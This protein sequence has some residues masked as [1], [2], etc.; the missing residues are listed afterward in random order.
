MKEMKTYKIYGITAAAVCLVAAFSTVSCSKDV[1]IGDPVPVNA[2]YLL[3][4]TGASDEDNARIMEIYEKWSSYVLYDV[5]SADVYWTQVAGTASGGT[6]VYQ[7]EDADPQYVG[8]MLYYLN[9]VW[10]QYFP[11]EFLQ[12][13]GIP[14]R[15]YLVE[16]YYKY[17]DWGSSGVSANTYLDYRIDDNYSYIIV[18]GMSKVASMDADTKRDKKFFLLN[19][20]FDKWTTKGVVD[21]PEEFYTISDYTTEP[22]MTGEGEDQYG[23]PVIAFTDEE[24]AAF[25][26]RGFIPKVT[27]Q[28]SMG[29]LPSVSISEIYTKYSETSSN[30]SSGYFDPKEEDFLAYISQM[31]YATEAEIEEFMKYETVK[32][33]WNI[34]LD[35]Y[36]DNYNIDLGAIASE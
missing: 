24:L 9:E 36:K 17:Q 23:N 26:N 19:A 33:K 8:D 16:E 18:S 12:K 2:G 34:I 28:Q 20:L 21:I 32:T 27:M 1:P 30:W 29:Q 4:Q 3:P 22:E 15:V 14:F 5:D 7:F 6:D 13:G 11:D 31:L 35:Y 25:R 10:W